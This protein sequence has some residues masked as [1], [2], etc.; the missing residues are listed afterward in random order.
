MHRFFAPVKYWR[1]IKTASV[2]K[3]DAAMKEI[4]RLVDRAVEERL[5]LH[6]YRAGPPPRDAPTTMSSPPG[7]ARADQAAADADQP[8]REVAREGVGSVPEP[9]RIID[10]LTDFH[11]ETPDAVT[12]ND[13]VKQ[14]ITFLFAG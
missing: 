3:Y 10:N 14:A 4:T 12:R 2:R 7:P 1:Y 11:A 5:A 9:E 13:I 8:C 6:R